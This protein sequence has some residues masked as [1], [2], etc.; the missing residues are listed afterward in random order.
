MKR[1]FP[2]I[3]FSQI[4]DLSNT[5]L[6]LTSL[7]SELRVKINHFLTAQHWFLQAFI[8]KS[9][10][11][12]FNWTCPADYR[13]IEI[14]IFLGLFA[15]FFLNR[16]QAAAFKWPIRMEMSSRPDLRCYVKIET[17]LVPTVC[18]PG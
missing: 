9:S 7:F 3:H 12:C 11:V 16:A 6:P 13:S 4:P 1:L 2:D 18:L 5:P 17:E 14:R 10:H 15:S 8:F